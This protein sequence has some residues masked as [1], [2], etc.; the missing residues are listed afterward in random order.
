MIFSMMVFLTH[1]K[2]AKIVTTG[3][4]NCTIGHVHLG[5]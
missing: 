5:R 4:M 1:F 2:Y 3:G